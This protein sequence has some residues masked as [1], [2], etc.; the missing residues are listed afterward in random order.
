MVR[1]VVN[2]PIGSG[3]SNNNALP[4]GPCT[5]IEVTPGSGSVTIRWKDPED[6]FWLPEVFGEDYPVVWA[7]TVLVR[8][9]KDYPA[10]PS[11]GTILI[12]STTRDQ[13]VSGGFVDDT[14]EAGVTY[15]YTL[16]SYTDKNV[17]AAITEN[18]FTAQT[19]SF[20]KV[21]E[22][23]EILDSWEEINLATGL[24]AY[25]DVYSIGNWKNVDYG[26]EGV[27]PMAIAGFDMDGYYD[28]NVQIAPEGQCRLR[29]FSL[30]EKGNWV[31][32]KV[33]YV[34]KNSWTS[35]E[36]LLWSP[37][38]ESQN[39]E[40]VLTMDK[41]E[42]NLGDLAIRTDSFEVT[43][44]CDL[45]FHTYSLNEIE[46]ITSSEVPFDG[47]TTNVSAINVE[48]P[49]T[50][51]ARSE[52]LKTKM[53][54]GSVNG[55][56]PSPI[57]T[58]LEGTVFKQIEN[59]VRQLITPVLK[60]CDNKYSPEV[61]DT[62]TLWIPSGY[63]IG[64]V[65]ESYERYSASYNGKTITSPLYS[66]LFPSQSSRIRHYN[67][68]AD[69]WSTRTEVGVGPVVEFVFGCID[70]NGA[71]QRYT[72][73]DLLIPGFCTHYVDPNVPKAPAGVT[74]ASASFS[75][76]PTLYFRF[77]D[78]DDPNWTATKIFVKPGYDLSVEEVITT[79][80]CILV[81][82]TKNQYQNGGVEG[83]KSIQMGHW[84]AV[85]AT[86]NGDLTDYSEAYKE[87]S[88]S[89]LMS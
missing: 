53:K 67:G 50:W 54:H 38:L 75:F 80:E 82:T 4:L 49:I 13:F 26:S 69:G 37:E 32:E 65:N 45:Y 84:T 11:D 85:I 34:K 16:F 73:C 46:L 31:A 28:P 39:K 25:K 15:Y 24:G 71:F 22:D 66:D 60:V 74:N 78:P 81:E 89:E 62:A 36:D 9:D 86:Y 30:N 41:K 77:T 58:H 33:L 8:S 56:V 44:H 48:A 43:D 10:K 27:I 5:G 3:G 29:L 57:R 83:P 42:P 20:G 68:Q 2:L 61:I 76:S 18:S 40:K 52:A 12:E 14:V 70:K 17:T 47:T 21:S 88:Y 19:Y 23:G 55:Y 6:T 7:K 35:F 79:G 51:I 72:D 1:A 64:V 59:Q 87:S 63:E